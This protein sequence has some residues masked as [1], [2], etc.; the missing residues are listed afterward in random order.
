MYL[1]MM[2]SLNS[3]DGDY[4]LDSKETAL[5]FIRKQ[6]G[7]AGIAYANAWEVNT[8]LAW[9]NYHSDRRHYDYGRIQHFYIDPANELITKE[10]LFK[11][12]L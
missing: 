9:D 5:L 3:S 4:L 10:T 2:I 1:V 6:Y 11:K 7:E 12:Y 8:Q